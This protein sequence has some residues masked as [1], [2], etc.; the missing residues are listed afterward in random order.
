MISGVTLLCC[1]SKTVPFQPRALLAALLPPGLYL[2]RGTVH[3]AAQAPPVAALLLAVAVS[4][5][6]AHGCT[7]VILCQ[8]APPVWITACSAWTT[9]AA[10]EITI[11]NRSAMVR[12]T[13]CAGGELCTNNGLAQVPQRASNTRSRH[14]VVVWLSVP[15]A[16]SR[17]G[18]TANYNGMVRHGMRTHRIGTP[19]PLRHSTVQYGDLLPFSA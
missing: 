13:Y 17:L 1:T 9:P 5:P 12:T 8:D 4:H 16:G 2:Q 18:G 15:V 7:C 10:S 3:R 19:S 11:S 14:A 6:C